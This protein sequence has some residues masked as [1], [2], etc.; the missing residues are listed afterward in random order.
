MNL[1][2]WH[3]MFA[4]LAGI[5]LN[6]T[7]CVLPILPLKIQTIL[8][9]IGTRVRAR[10]L[11]AFAYLI[12]CVSFFS[13]LAIL[14]S[15]LDYHWGAIFQSEIFL[16]FL[17]FILFWAAMSMFCDW[18]FYFP[19]LAYHFTAKRYVG[20]FTTGAL[21]GILSTPCSGPLLASVLAY[22][23]TQ[24]TA[25][26]W[27]LFL[28]I[29]LGLAFPA[30]ML[31]LSPALSGYFQFTRKWGRQIKTFFAF[32]LLAGALFFLQVILHDPLLRKVLWWA[33]ISGVLLW[34]IVEHREALH[35]SECLIPLFTLILLSSSLVVV[36]APHPEVKVHWRNYSI[37]A[38]QENILEHQPILLTFTADWCL[39][40]K[41]LERT[42]YLDRKL[43]HAI[44]Q[45]QIHPYL[46]DM[47]RYNKQ[48][49]DILSYYGGN[50]LPYAV[51]I[52]KDGNILQKFTGMFSAQTMLDVI[53]KE[54]GPI[55][56]ENRREL[57]LP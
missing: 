39:N 41:I 26:I 1:M 4:F 45:A 16:V 14:V 48:Y 15:V 52:A 30:V 36:F 55:V 51:L 56:S 22:T 29:A 42:T 7:P 32:V 19:R 49:K 43:V 5:L 3:F 37:H 9:G 47:T 11:A 31:L 33:Y 25:V 57:L 35:F 10:M 24:S 2:L 23:M 50:A 17:A 13:I 6:F 44:E 20:A 53:S 27:F 28:G 21:A 12:G 8:N 38:L 34:V 18:K 46:I 40:C 54:W